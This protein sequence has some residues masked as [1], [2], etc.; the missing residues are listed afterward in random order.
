MSTLP[1]PPS[2]PPALRQSVIVTDIDMT[3]GAMCRF[4]VKWAIAAIP[5]FILIWIIF[6]A[7]GLAAALLFGGVIHG[8]MGAARGGF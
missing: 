6:V 5:A 1:L 4:M 8:L 7:V 2:Y 3:I